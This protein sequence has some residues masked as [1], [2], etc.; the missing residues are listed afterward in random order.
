[1]FD[2]WPISVSLE[3]K[4]LESPTAFSGAAVNSTLKS[5]FDVLLIMSI[6]PSTAASSTAICLASTLF[7]TGIYS[8][9]VNFKLG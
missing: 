1:M 5:P 2:V 9:V 7:C 3:I 8:E 4:S 6:C